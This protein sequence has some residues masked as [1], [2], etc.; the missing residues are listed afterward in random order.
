M[1][2]SPS[3]KTPQKIFLCIILTYKIEY[4]IISIDNKH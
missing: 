1:S 4:A 2:L 3:M